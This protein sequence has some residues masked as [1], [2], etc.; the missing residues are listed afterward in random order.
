ML[1]GLLEAKGIH[2]D[3]ANGPLTG[4]TEALDHHDAHG[5]KEKTSLKQKIKDKLHKH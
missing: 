4:N 3:N 1:L 5:H 2:R